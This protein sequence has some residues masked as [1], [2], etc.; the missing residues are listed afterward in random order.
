MR[1]L[2]E[3]P[4]AKQAEEWLRGEIA[5]ALEQHIRP[6]LPP[7]KYKLTLIARTEDK[8]A[9]NVVVTEDDMPAA[10]R[11]LDGEGLERLA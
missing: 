8:P 2:R 5:T 11:V 6:L 4:S 3:G 9:G 7:W 1:E 10:A